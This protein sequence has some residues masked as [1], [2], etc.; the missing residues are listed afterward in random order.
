[1]FSLLQE[2]IISF[3]TNLY[4]N[5]YIISHIK[6]KIDYIIVILY[7]P[8]E[9]YGNLCVKFFLWV[10]ISIKTPGYVGFYYA[11]NFNRDNK[12]TVYEVVGIKTKEN[13]NRSINC[14]QFS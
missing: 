14:F 1:M 13:F 3:I 5:Q 9:I 6:P 8:V 7:G 11:I 4:I 12:Y 2:R 10:D